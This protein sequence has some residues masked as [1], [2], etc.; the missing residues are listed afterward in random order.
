MPATITIRP[1]QPGDLDRVSTLLSRSYRALLA[2]DYEP[3]VLRDALPLITRAR[4]QLM[5]CGTYFI[6]ADDTGRALAAGGWTD[7]TP[8]GAAG[9]TGIGHARHVATDPDHT[10]RGLARRVLETTMASARDAGVRHLHC[11]STLTARGFY[12]RLGFETRGR[13][14]IR[15]M[16]GVYFPAYHLRLEL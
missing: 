7:A 2:P 11:Q 13:I 6:A 8:S 3:A 9:L 12:E 5:R 14:D 4:P 16:P 1:A 15:L 10:G